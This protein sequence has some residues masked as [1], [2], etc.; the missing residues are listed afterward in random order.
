MLMMSFLRQPG[1]GSGAALPQEL[2]V[3]GDDQHAQAPLRQLPEQA[4]HL[5]HVGVVQPAG[6]FVENQQFFPA[7]AAIHDGKPLLLPAGQVPGRIRSAQAPGSAGCA[8]SLASASTLSPKSWRFI[9]MIKPF[10][11]FRSASHRIVPAC[12]FIKPHKHRAKV[13]LPAPL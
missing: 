6:G 13:V 10:R 4:A 8:P 12:S 9:R 1:N 3:V 7:E 11:L 5:Q 2:P